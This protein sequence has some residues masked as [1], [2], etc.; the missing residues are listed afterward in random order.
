ME[1][2]QSAN[3]AYYN[4]TFF[5]QTRMVNRIVPVIPFVISSLVVSSILRTPGFLEF[6]RESLLNAHQQANTPLIVTN[7]VIHET[8]HAT[9]ER[10]NNTTSSSS[11]LRRRPRLSSLLAD[12]R[13]QFV[14]GGRNQTIL[15]DVQFL[16]DFAIV[17]FPKCGTSSMS[18]LLGAHPQV[19]I[20]K[21][22]MQYLSLSKPADA[23]WH[24]YTKLGVQTAG[25]DDDDHYYV[26]GYKSPFDVT[27]RH[28]KGPYGAMDYI[29]QYFSTTKLIVGV[30]HP[31]RWFES[32]YNFRLQRGVYVP[33][34]NH[35]IKR[36]SHGFGVQQANFHV[37]LAAL[38]LV[39]MTSPFQTTLRR[40]FPQ[41]L[42]TLPPPISN[43]VFFY[44]MQQ[45]AD[46]NTTR[47]DL[48]LHDLQTFLGLEPI[49]SLPMVQRNAG[50]VKQPQLDYIDIC[51]S[52][53]NQLRR[54]LLHVSK[55]ASTWIRTYWLHADKVYYSSREYL[56]E[57]LQSWMQD[58]CPS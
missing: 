28:V 2:L 5:F 55:Q 54:E 51:D 41:Q 4:P 13:R 57:L 26:R 30:R 21:R 7:A 52:K 39:N 9:T 46:G 3:G 18:A 56:E 53:Y 24:L 40:Q 25:D 48:F 35:L 20:H 34:P 37:Y 10:K 23:I 38:G 1:L 58:P 11:S 14:R 32:F 43:D 36:Q 42:Q 27:N 45:L 49:M 33:K 6:Y 29:R 16:L 15:G 44:D 19:Q 47:S 50:K 17:G 22:E 8:T 12:S 31:V